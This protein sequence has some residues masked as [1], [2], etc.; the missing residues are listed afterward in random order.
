MERSIRLDWQEIVVEAVK[1]RK[2]QKLTQQQLA[3]IADVSKPTLNNFEQGRTNITLD[4]A[5][6]I[7]RCLGLA[8][9]H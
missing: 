7:L 4:T 9:Q 1:R 8:A 5:L 3:V 2:Q 6:K